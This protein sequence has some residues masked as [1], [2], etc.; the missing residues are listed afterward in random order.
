MLV[1][2]MSILF[3]CSVK[4]NQLDQKLKIMLRFTYTLLGSDAIQ[5]LP[6]LILV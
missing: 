4:V 5:I 3:V 2:V 6:I 1:R